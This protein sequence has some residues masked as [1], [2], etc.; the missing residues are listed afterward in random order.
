MA[1]SCF[2]RLNN[3]VCHV[4][5]ARGFSLHRAYRRARM[6]CIYFRIFF[7]SNESTQSLRKIFCQPKRSALLEDGKKGEEEGSVAAASTLLSWSGTFAGRR[8]HARPSAVLE[9]H[10][11]T[12]GGRAHEPPF[13]LLSVRPS[14]YTPKGKRRRRR[15]ARAAKAHP[16][17]PFLPR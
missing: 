17:P 12:E 6:E 3:S 16:F 5:V 11:A 13:S 10:L 9:A 4:G 14:V 8:P 15:R 7:L 2:L 1:Q